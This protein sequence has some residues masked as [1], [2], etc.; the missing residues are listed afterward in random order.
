MK[1][2]YSKLFAMVSLTISFFGPVVA[3]AETTNPVSAVLLKCTQ[4][5][6]ACG[7]NELIELVNGMVQY[8]VQ[9]IG[10]VFVIILVY[11]GF[12]YMTSGGDAA[13]VKKAKDMIYKVALGF[14][15]TLCGW[16]IVYFIIQ[17]LGVLPEFYNTIIQP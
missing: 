12:I 5:G 11:T 1:N 4:P 9:I 6:V 7:Y 3:F 17:K 10:I 14:V 2:I 8:G 13:K 16:I 15:Y